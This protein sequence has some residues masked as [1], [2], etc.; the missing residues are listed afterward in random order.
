MVYLV[1]V[2]SLACLPCSRLPRL[3]M[4]RVDHSKPAIA[5]KPRDPADLAQ[6]LPGIPSHSP[7]EGRR[8]RET[9]TYNFWNGTKGNRCPKL[10]RR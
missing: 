6:S 10:A 9:V 5:A 3:R 8:P 4:P 2:S 1:E 7:I